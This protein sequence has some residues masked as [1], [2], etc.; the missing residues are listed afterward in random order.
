MYHSITG[1]VESI[2]EDSIIIDNNGI[3]FQ[4][5]CS[6]KTMD[7]IIEDVKIG[8]LGHKIFIILEHKE[9]SMLL[10]G[11]KTETE[12]GVFEKLIK[13]SGVGSKVALR[14]LS[15]LTVGQ[16]RAAINNKDVRTLCSIK[17]FGEKSALKLI[18]EVK[19]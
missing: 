2:K 13:V 6:S 3:E 16:L 8:N 12:K 17:G 18:K 10:Y 4:V 11:F 7:V 1:I 15:G 9:N 14:V 5:F 19:L